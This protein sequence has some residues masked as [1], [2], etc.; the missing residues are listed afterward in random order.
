ML[1]IIVLF[2]MLGDMVTK[3]LTFFESEGQVGLWAEWL[4]IPILFGISALIIF[5][6]FVRLY[7]H[8]FRKL[9]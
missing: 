7:F 1:F 9:V 4:P 3:S 2:D 5:I 6:L 8:P